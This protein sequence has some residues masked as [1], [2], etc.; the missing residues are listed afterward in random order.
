MQLINQMYLQIKE[1]ERKDQ[2]K[3]VEQT[4]TLNQKIDN[5]ADAICS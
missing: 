3:R 4:D 5:M 1:L 2:S